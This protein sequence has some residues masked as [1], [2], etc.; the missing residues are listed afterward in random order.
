MGVNRVPHHMPARTDC[1]RWGAF[2]ADS[3][4]ASPME[5]FDFVLEQVPQE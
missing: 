1:K 2:D 4:Q 3:R 5:L